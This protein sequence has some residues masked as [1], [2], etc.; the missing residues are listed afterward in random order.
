M[1]IVAESPGQSLLLWCKES[2]KDLALLWVIYKDRLHLGHWRR[3]WDGASA[4]VVLAV[5][6]GLS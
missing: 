2:M 4:S 3:V 6:M 1:S 5:E